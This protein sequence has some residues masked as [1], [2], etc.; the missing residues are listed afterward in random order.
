[1]NLNEKVLFSSEE[2]RSL[3]EIIAFLRSIADRLEQQG[4]VT[5]SQGTQQV[6]VRPEGDIVL[7]VKYEV[8]PKK[9]QLEIEIEWRPGGGSVTV[10]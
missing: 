1:M 9:H 4:A 3:P 2:R 5:L 10:G 8:E 6:Q 7:E